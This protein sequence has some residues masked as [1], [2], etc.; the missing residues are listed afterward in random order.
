[1]SNGNGTW[2]DRAMGSGLIAT[3]AWFILL[4]LYVGAQSL[5]IEAPGIHTA[6]TMLT[7]GWVAMLT[8]AQSRRSQ[9]NEELK[10]TPKDATNQ[11]DSES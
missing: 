9:K 1:M 4:C 7:G 2:F 10:N 5:S 3:I 8:L 11:E 6:F